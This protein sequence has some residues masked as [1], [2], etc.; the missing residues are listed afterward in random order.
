MAM[1]TNWLTFR[2]AAFQLEL[3]EA[4]EY[5]D[6]QA[7]NAVFN[8]ELEKMIRRLSNEE[9]RQQVSELRGFNW[10]GYL[11]RSLRRAGFKDDDIQEY[12]HQITIQLLLEPG[13]LYRGWLPGKHG[14]L[15]RR[16]RRSVWNA[17]R[18]IQEKGRNRRKWMTAVDPSVMAGQHAGRAPYSDV[19]DQFRSLVA[20][21]LGSLALEILD[22]R[23]AGED[24]KNL[25][26]KT[27]IG[28][29]SAYYI[30]REVSAIKQLAYQFA[31]QTG[32]QVFLYK[33]VKA[34][35]SEKA[36]TAKRQA[37]IAAK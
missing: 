33:L 9:V 24:I 25:V 18:N 37:A 3:L 19:V 11:E 30:K 13:K 29:P 27:T 21:R 1:F 22:A 15:D 31:Q 7:Y 17:I 10:G 8:S 36:T 12:F 32:D 2:D 16:F 23:L 4:A 14:P 34:M 6:P 35:D 26:G 5:F 28:T 20:Q